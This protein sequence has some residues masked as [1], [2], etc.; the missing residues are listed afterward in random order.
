MHFVTV[1]AIQSRRERTASTISRCAQRLADERGL[2]GFT[3]DQLA[4]AAGVSRRTL[5]NYF[6]GK[7][8]AVLGTEEEPDASVFEEFAAG[9][10]TGELVDDLRHMVNRFLT[11]KRTDAESV[12][13]VRRLLR[14]DA[15]LFHAAHDRFESAAEQF[16]DFIAA[17]EGDDF[18]PRRAR[19]IARL[20]LAMFDL[21]LDA[22]LEDP[23]RS[24]V[25][26]FNQTL[27]TAHDLLG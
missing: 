2:D 23:D 4:E 9:G 14:N 18:D 21:A 15:R 16:A 7:V 3:M 5:F 22:F 12:A 13:R 10:P 1:S 26:H 17:R 25:E 6:D 24:L 8:D 27:D 20:L 19:I 11:F